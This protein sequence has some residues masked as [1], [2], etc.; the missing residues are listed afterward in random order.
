[1]IRFILQ[2]GDVTRMTNDVKTR[3]T[4]RMPKQLY[5][6]LD[7]RANELGV[8]KNALILQVLWSYLEEQNKNE[9]EVEK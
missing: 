7:E 5:S 9:R 2:G 1:M 6:K 3:F 4:F 8:S